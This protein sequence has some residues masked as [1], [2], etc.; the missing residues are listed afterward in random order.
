LDSPGMAH[1]RRLCARF[2]GAVAHLRMA[3]R[4]TDALL[5]VTFRST[6]LALGLFVTLVVLKQQR[7][8]RRVLRDNRGSL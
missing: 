2:R 6:A 5:Q 1:R 3:T 8:P 4:L 7:G